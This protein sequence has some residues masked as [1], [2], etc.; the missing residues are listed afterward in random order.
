MGAER[1]KVFPEPQQKLPA[2]HKD[3]GVG[4]NPET[5]I[6]VMPWCAPGFAFIMFPCMRAGELG[7]AAPASGDR[8]VLRVDPDCWGMGHQRP[9]WAIA[10]CLSLPLPGARRVYVT[11]D[12]PRRFWEVLGPKVQNCSSQQ[13]YFVCL[14][15]FP[16]GHLFGSWV[17]VCPKMT[18]CP[19]FHMRSWSP[20]LG[21]PDLLGEA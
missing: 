1:K 19:A 18:W 3:G 6:W 5:A 8:E 15:W 10:D 16:R 12:I 20:M 2:P 4:R 17:L 21:A 7:R 14:D 13:G 11:L 9:P